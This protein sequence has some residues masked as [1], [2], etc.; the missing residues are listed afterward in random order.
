MRKLVE[1]DKKTEIIKG[2]IKAGAYK[3]DPVNLFPY[4][5]GKSGP[6]YIDLRDILLNAKLPLR[7]KIVN[8]MVGLID[9]KCQNYTITYAGAAG[10]TFGADVGAELETERMYDRGKPKDHGISDT[11]VGKASLGSE[12]AIID[13]VFNE[14]T[15][16]KISGNNLLDKGILPK[17]IF[18]VVNRSN[19]R[20]RE[21]QLKDGS[22]VP[23]YS[24]FDIEDLQKELPS[25]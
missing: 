22:I 18:V 2:I 15:S 7:K 1:Q 19:P 21:V 11:I 14:G 10:S 12:S 24:L 5:G 17:G 8:L 6:T 9:S 25:K 20:V 13:D 16:V 23:V 4:K 3:Y